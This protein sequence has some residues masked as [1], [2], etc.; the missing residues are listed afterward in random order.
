MSLF[1]PRKI[2]PN[3][4]LKNDLENTV[5]HFIIELKIFKKYLD[6]S[7]VNINKIFI[8]YDKI[9]TIKQEYLKLKYLLKKKLD[10]K[11]IENNS[12]IIKFKKYRI[13][14]EEYEKNQLILGVNLKTKELTTIK[15]V[16]NETVRI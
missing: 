5:L 16:L 10:N 7:S 9:K 2:D 4:K 6:E 1:F 3:A 13:V 11:Y 15:S 12:S 14:L 8:Q